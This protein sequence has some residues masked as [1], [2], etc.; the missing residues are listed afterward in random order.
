MSAL[1]VAEFR[2][3]LTED[4]LAE[5]CAIHEKGRDFRDVTA[6][7][8]NVHPKRLSVWL[9]RG[10]MGGDLTSPFVRLFLAFGRIEGDL[11]AKC[12]D[13]VLDTTKETIKI[14]SDGKGG[15]TKDVIKRDSAGVRWY[16]ERRFRSYRIEALPTDDNAEVSTMLNADAP[17][18]K[19]AEAAV[20]VIR[21]LAAAM[22]PELMRVFVESPQ[23]REAFAKQLETA[24]AQE[25]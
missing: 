5:L 9:R 21:Q 2:T 22:P 12:I 1:T 6:V 23:F 11:R 16:M 18:V 24:H 3:E 15:E 19:N 8:C 4:V 13:E 20:G 25:K 10:A 14:V 7:R 17:Q